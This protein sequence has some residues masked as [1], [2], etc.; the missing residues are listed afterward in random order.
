M[1]R[2]WHIRH[3]PAIS[4][5][6]GGGDNDRQ[7]RTS[8]GIHKSLRRVRQM[9]G[10]YEQIATADGENFHWLCQQRHGRESAVDLPP[11]NKDIRR[12]D[13]VM[14]TR[15]C[16]ILWQL[17]TLHRRQQ[18]TSLADHPSSSVVASSCG[19]GSEL[20]LGRTGSKSNLSARIAVRFW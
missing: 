15:G 9:L 16:E 11:I 5:R 4:Q 10:G 18:T 14:R 13:F 7:G 2:L 1:H 12:F 20:A 8:Q 6:Q 19:H 17:E 3:R